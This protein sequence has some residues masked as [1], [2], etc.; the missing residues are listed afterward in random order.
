MIF[1]NILIITTVFLLVSIL[2]YYIFQAKKNADY[3]VNLETI[4]SEY[5][6]YKLDRGEWYSLPIIRHTFYD[7]FVVVNGKGE[8]EKIKFKE[9]IKVTIDPVHKGYSYFFKYS[10]EYDYFSFKYKERRSVILSTRCQ[11]KVIE[12]FK[13]NK[14]E[15]INNT[16]HF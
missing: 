11:K 4:H 5:S 7:D 16:K 8:N 10:I 1:N 2:I 3:E 12:I 6:C 14:V 13:N 9:I 15:V